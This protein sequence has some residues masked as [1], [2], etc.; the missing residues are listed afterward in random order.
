MLMP[1]A[2][3]PTRGPRRILV[4]EDHAD[5]AEMLELALSAVGHTVRLAA[6]GATALAAAR[7]FEPQIVLCDIGLPGMSGYEVA[8]LL[9]Q[10]PGSRNAFL[11]ALTGYGRDED[12]ER[13]R[14][15]GFDLHLTKP[16]DVTQLQQILS[17]HGAAD[18]RA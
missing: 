15:A 17:S 2:P 4:V 14:E 5:A 16:L 9:R 8:G 10:E 12:R 1:D 3:G 11:V 6:D 13:C 7:E 18:G